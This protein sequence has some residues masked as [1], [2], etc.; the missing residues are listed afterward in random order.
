MNNE[1]KH[2]IISLR[3]SNDEERNADAINVDARIHATCMWPRERIEKDGEVKQSRTICH[4]SCILQNIIGQKG[5][6]I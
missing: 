4:M 2:F 3:R 1:D 5:F 6:K